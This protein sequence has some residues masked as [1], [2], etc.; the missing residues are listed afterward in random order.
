MENIGENQ[1]LDV[2]RKGREGKEE[3]E[4]EEEERGKRYKKVTSGFP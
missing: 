4:E 3:E 1:T 2:K